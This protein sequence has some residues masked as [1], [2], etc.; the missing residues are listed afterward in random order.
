MSHPPATPG[1]IGASP[2]K[3]GFQFGP[4]RANN[5]YYPTPKSATR[6][7]LAAHRFN[8]SVWEPACGEGWL[9]REL[10]AAQYDTV[11]TDIA[12]YGYGTSDVDFLDQRLPR[13]KNICTNPPYGRGLADAFV[14]KA[15]WFIDRTGGEAAMLLNIASLCHPERHN[16]FVRRPPAVLYL[17]DQCVCYPNGY[18]EHATRHTTQ[19]KYAW[20]VWT[21]GPTTQCLTR[22]LST[23]PYEDLSSITST[24]NQRRAS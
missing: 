24:F 2:F 4:V 9:S 8:G 1:Q 17:L 10:I 19:H 18:P 7:F 6:A 22:W 14:R 15:L 12:E 21:A 13:A 3:A 16:S 23:R 11:S 5:E 20:A